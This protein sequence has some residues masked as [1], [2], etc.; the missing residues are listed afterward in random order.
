MKYDVFV[1][2]RRSSFESA[3]LIAEKMRSKGYSVFFDVETLRSGKFNEQ[4]YEVIDNCNDFIL[5]LPP[6]ALDKCHNEEDWVRR[7]LIR[8][9][10]GNKNIVP[11]QLA[12]FEWPSPMPQGLEELPNY[13]AIIAGEQ[14][15]FDMSM[16]RLAGYLKSK[17]HRDM[18]KFY[19]RFAIILASIL[20]VLGLIGG[21]IMHSAKV[22][23]YDVCVC[24]TQE[25]TILN[26]VRKTQVNYNKLW[27]E[28]NTY[29]KTHNLTKAEI[30]QRTEKIH[31]SL[32]VYGQEIVN[33]RDKVEK[34]TKFTSFEKFLLG[35]YGYTPQDI[36]AFSGFYDAMFDM[37]LQDVSYLKSVTSPSIQDT[38]KFIAEKQF[39]GWGCVLQSLY[40]NYMAEIAKMPAIGKEYY[41]TNGKFIAIEN[42]VTLNMDQSEYEKLAIAEMGKYQSIAAEIKLAV[43]KQ[44][45]TIEQ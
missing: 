17:P 32:H 29:I 26:A 5:V 13:Q 43:E 27:Q 19:K 6:N 40:Y 15:F 3:N 33:M 38:Q 35:L 18:R 11:V 28:Y 21:V 8:A 45:A 4:L 10:Q 12:G 16:D 1:S 42:T 25:F 36:S 34:Y 30:A 44:K 2:Y 14:E 22:L 41:Y 23:C 7:E 9:M 37:A 39:E 24:L 20:V 31:K